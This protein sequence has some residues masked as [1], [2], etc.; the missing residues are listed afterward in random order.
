MPYLMRIACTMG[1]E[2]FYSFDF[3]VS[4]GLLVGTPNLSIFSLFRSCPP[5]MSGGKCI[6]YP[7]CAI[8]PTR[9]CLAADTTVCS[10]WSELTKS[11]P[12]SA[13]EGRYSCQPASFSAFS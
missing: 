10:N 12:L 1:T 4:V 8:L 6:T 13:E 7:V 2:I 9:L 3:F 11:D 5:G